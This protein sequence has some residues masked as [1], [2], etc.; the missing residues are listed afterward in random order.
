MENAKIRELAEFYRKH[1]LEDVMPFW[2]A[3]TRDE[4][5]GGY[6]TCFDRAGNVTDPGKYIWFQARQAY[7]FAALYNQVEPR[8]LWLD[9]ARCGRDYLVENAYAGD[10]RWNYRLDRKGNVLEGTISIFTDGYALAALSE[11]ATASNSSEDR[12]L[13]QDTYDALER[14]TRDPEFKDLFHDTWDPRFKR[15]GVYFIA[16]DSAQVA[17][18]V[19]GDEITRPLIDLCLHEI[20]YVFANDE[21]QTHYDNI[22]RDGSVL[23]IEECR[24]LNPGHT[25]ES[26]W[27]C[28]EEGLHR[29]HRETVDRALTI[30]DWAYER[31]YDREHGGIV[32]FLDA[33]GKEPKQMDWHKETN[34]MWHDKAWWVHSEALHT[35]ALAVVHRGNEESDLDRFLDLHSWCQKHF[36]DP[37]YGEWYAELHRDGTPK[38]TDKGTIWKAAYHLPRALMKIAGAFSLFGSSS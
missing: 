17:R 12:P 1:L 9:L 25:L 35:L 8:P 10:G 37:E 15:H 11:F 21:T 34:M 2:E 13:I 26:M 6:L 32:S 29:G 7:M 27:F 16:L 23:D 4:T 14:S 30:T 24:V 33:S 28:I 20:L 19:L 38:L 5:A 22:G 31:G 3:R 18:Q 36:Y